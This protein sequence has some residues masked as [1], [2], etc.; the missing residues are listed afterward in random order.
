MTGVTTAVQFFGGTTVCAQ[1]PCGTIAE[2]IWWDY[3]CTAL[4]GTTG[5]QPTGG[6][7]AA[8]PEGG[9]INV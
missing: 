9:T 3:I 2:A 5:V 6:A 4:R 7:I 1:P 8:L